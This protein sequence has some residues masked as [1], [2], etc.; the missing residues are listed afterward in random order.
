MRGQQTSDHSDSIWKEYKLRKLTFTQ[1][2]TAMRIQNSFKI[3]TAVTLMVMAT[4]HT[5]KNNERIS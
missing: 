3:S 4:I 5:G 2:K 1:L